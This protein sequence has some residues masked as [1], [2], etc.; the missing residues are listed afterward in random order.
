MFNVDRPEKAPESLSKRKSYREADVLEALEKIF[1][2]K[3]YLCETKEPQD[4]QI[5]HFVAHQND[6]DKKYDWKNLYYVCSRCNNIK[7]ANFNNLIDCCDP[8]QDVT[9][10]IKLMLPLSPGASTITI[11][12]QRNDDQVKETEKLLEQ[13]YN[14]DQTKNKKVSGSYLRKKIHTQYNLLYKWIMI[15]YAA[16][17]TEEDKQ[18]ALDHI[19]ILISPEAQYSAFSYWCIKEDCELRCLLE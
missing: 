12:R 3:C 9:K 2:K 10:A 7:N 16:D 5:E 11:K 14:S 13:I 17:A 1:H 18:N 6:D 19:K 15:Y 4:I 8:E